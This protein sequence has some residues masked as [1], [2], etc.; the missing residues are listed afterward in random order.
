M[1]LII[2]VGHAINVP[3]ASPIV[4][5]FIVGTR[6]ATNASLTFSTITLEKSLYMG[7]VCMVKPHG[8]TLPMATKRGGFPSTNNLH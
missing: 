4:L 1:A 6:T 5:T 2:C 3:S 8:Y 7:M